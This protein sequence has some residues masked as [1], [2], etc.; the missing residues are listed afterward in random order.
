MWL[1]EGFYMLEFSWKVICVILLRLLSMY[2]LFSCKVEQVYSFIPHFSGS[3]FDNG[4]ATLIQCLSS[5]TTCTVSTF[6]LKWPEP[7][8][9]EESR[10]WFEGEG[11]FWM[12]SLSPG[13]SNQSGP[14]LFQSAGTDSSYWAWETETKKKKKPCHLPTPGFWVREGG[15][16]QNRACKPEVVQPSPQRESS[17]PGRSGG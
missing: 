6:P 5:L 17:S 10:V 13:C 9:S 11:A 15:I 8:T 12:S 7:V 3:E 2:H 1:F 14:A 16:P 4:Q